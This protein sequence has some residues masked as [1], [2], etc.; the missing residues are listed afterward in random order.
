MGHVPYAGSQKKASMGNL[1]SIS[2]R[3]D[4]TLWYSV[5]IPRKDSN[6]ATESK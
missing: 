3:S 4:S 2:S 6:Q 1:E 5:V